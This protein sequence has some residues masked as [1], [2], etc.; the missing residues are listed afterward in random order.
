MARPKTG[1]HVDVLRLLITTAAICTAAQAVEFPAGTGQPNDPYQIATAQQLI[2]ISQDPNLDSGH[3]VLVADLDLDP[4]LSGCRVFHGPIIA[5]SATR[6]WHGFPEPFQGT[7]DG[8]G[9]A[10]RNGIIYNVSDDQYAGLFES[11]GSRATVSD[12]TLEAFVVIDASEDG[13][14]CGVLA[15][16]NE[17][18][19]INCFATGTVIASSADRGLALGGG[20][21]GLNRGVV[22]DCHTRCYL[23]GGSAGGLVGA[24]Y[25]G[26]PGRI[27]FCSADGVVHRC[28]A[29]SRTG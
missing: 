5:W 29:A 2:A 21:I 24:N 20:L 11:I 26:E 15:G 16:Q 19:V 8:Q 17:G 1:P 6:G 7:F 13:W 4:N 14:P 10:I 23:F 22:S 12:L 27:T 28:C 9:H 25:V 18:R 3:F